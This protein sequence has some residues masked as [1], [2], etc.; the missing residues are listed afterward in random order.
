MQEVDPEPR[1]QLPFAVEREERVVHRVRVLARDPAGAELGVE[2]A[3]VLVRRDPEAGEVLER[4]ERAPLP[5]LRRQEL[6]AQQSGARGRAGR[7]AADRAVGGDGHARASSQ[8][9]PRLFVLVAALGRLD[10][11]G[12]VDGV[13]LGQVR[14]ALLGKLHGRDR[15]DRRDELAGRDLGAPRL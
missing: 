12:A 3:L 7:A 6:L 10:V 2:R 11:D 8:A 15:A 5:R 4:V 13:E 1:R 14:Q 9:L